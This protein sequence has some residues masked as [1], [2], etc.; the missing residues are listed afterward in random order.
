MLLNI[1]GG[2]EELARAVKYLSDTPDVVVQVESEYSLES[3]EEQNE[4]PGKE[5]IC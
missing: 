2:P 5:E 4:T 1:P 3:N